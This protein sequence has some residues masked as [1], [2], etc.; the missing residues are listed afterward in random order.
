[1]AKTTKADA[2]ILAKQKEYQREIERLADN[3]QQ[4]IEN[5]Q[6]MNTMF[7]AINSAAD[8]ARTQKPN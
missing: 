5:V 7:A 8:P 2:T 1:M 6:T 3:W 4:L